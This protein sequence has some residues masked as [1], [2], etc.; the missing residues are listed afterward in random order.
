MERRLYSSSGVSVRPLLCGL[1]VAAAFSTACGSSGVT[2]TTGPTATRCQITATNSASNFGVSG[3]DGTVTISVPRECSWSAASQAAWISITTAKDGQGDG[4]IGYHVAANPDPL[5]RR[6]S[7]TIGDQ[8]ADVAQDPAPCRFDVSGPADPLAAGGGDAT[9][10]VQTNSLCN[11]TA[12]SDALWAVVNPTSGAGAASVRVTAAPN[13]G[14]AR[15]ATVTVA[16]IRV[17]IAP[18]GTGPVPAP[19]PTPGPAPPPPPT[20]TPTP[21]PTPAPTP[22]PAPAPTPTPDPTPT[23]TPTPAPQDI[24]LSGK[25][26]QVKG[27]CPSLTFML[28]SH[29]VRTSSTTTFSNGSC[30]NVKNDT[31]VSVHGTLEVDGSVDASSVTIE[32]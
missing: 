25:V 8:H 27:E 3:G 9:V 10:T 20:P 17:T 16:G 5:T 1:I 31:K 21:S 28:Q 24:D 32:K 19:I 15:T 26:S 6:G 18:M 23:P 14:A 13:T 22:G 4:S 11:W 7:I 30:K 12:A 29:L 2:N